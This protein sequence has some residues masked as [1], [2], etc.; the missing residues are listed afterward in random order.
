MKITL[1]LTERELTTIEN[2]LKDAKAKV[3]D[4]YLAEYNDMEKRAIDSESVDACCEGLLRNVHMMEGILEKI[5]D[6]EIE[7]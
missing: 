6:A 3:F 2:L 1:D 5:E 4:M 7:A